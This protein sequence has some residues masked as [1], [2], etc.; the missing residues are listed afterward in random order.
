MIFANGATSQSANEYVFANDYCAA[1]QR[2]QLL[3]AIYDPVTRACLERID[4]AEGWSCWEV[5]AGYGT[6]ARWLADR[7]GST[8]QVLATDL[9]TRFL[10]PLRSPTLQVSRH[11]IVRDE[12]PSQRFDL[13]HARLLLCH[14]RERE[15]VMDRMI[16]TLKPGGWL[17]IEDYDGL[18]MLPDPGINPSERSLQ[19]ASAFRELMRQ[20]GVDLRFGRRVVGL[21][22]AR[23]LRQI[24][25]EGRVFMSL[26]GSAYARL[27]RLGLEQVRDELLKLRLIAPEEYVRDLAAMEH[28]FTAP[29][30]LLWSVVGRR[31]M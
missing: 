27:Q 19:V 12:L 20:R 24:S 2:L 21:L 31:A 9:D 5:G 7:V 18:S 28:D 30:A 6:I 4:V 17:V 25:A 3:A 22:R 26:D 16:E 10:V 23:G 1:S 8:G 13:V 15:Q 11:D 29:L 14:L